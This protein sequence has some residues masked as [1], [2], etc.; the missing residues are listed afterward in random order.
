[1]ASLIRKTALTATLAAL[2]AA[3]GC[4]KPQITTG[5]LDSPSDYRDR[6]PIVIDTKVRST[7]IYPMRGPGGLNRRQSDDIKDLADEFRSNGRGHVMVLLPSNAGRDQQQTLGFIRKE[8]KEAGIPAA[9]VRTSH[10]EPLNPSKVS[11]VK[12]EFEV[13]AAK[14]A[15]ECG[16]WEQDILDGD[17]SASF[18]NRQYKNFGCSYQSI[19]AAQVADP[20]DLSRPRRL[21]EGD[22]GKRTDDVT[23]LRSDKDPSTNWS[24]NAAAVGQ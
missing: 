4:A 8:L 15:G 17:T 6:H 5:S 19:L 14:V 12:I 24:N 1:M 22:L 21:S 2:L 3:G 7:S 13:L 20:A 11:P 16:K 10:Y 18:D 9:Y 23:Q